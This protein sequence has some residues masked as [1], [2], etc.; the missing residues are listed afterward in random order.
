MQYIGS[1]QKS[2][3]F[4]VE[5]SD[6][7]TELVP[8]TDGTTIVTIFTAVVIYRHKNVDHLETQ[9]RAAKPDTAAEPTASQSDV[10]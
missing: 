1:V 3:S 4:L 9:E 10:F 6:H 8:E 2:S 7:K 5:Q